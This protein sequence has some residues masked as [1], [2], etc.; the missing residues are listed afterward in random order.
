MPS[1]LLTPHGRMYS[2]V[3]GWLFLYQAATQ[4]TD[5]FDNTT[6]FLADDGEP[7][8]DACLILLP[9]RGWQTREEGGYLLGA[10]ELVVEVAYSSDAYDL[11]SKRCDYE[12]AGV[13]EYVVVVLREQRVVWFIRQGERFEELAPGEDGLFRSPTFSGW[14]EQH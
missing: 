2:Q 11:H 13:L 8:P 10:P 6:V 9:D 12:R 14:M 3:M 5:L 1:P 7:Q 4:G